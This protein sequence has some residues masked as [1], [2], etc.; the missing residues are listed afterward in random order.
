MNTKAIEY[1]HFQERSCRVCRVFPDGRL[2]ICVGHNRSGALTR[3]VGEDEVTPVSAGVVC[4]FPT[5]GHFGKNGPRGR[6]VRI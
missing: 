4:D 6:R 2:E 1:V 3:I 5:K